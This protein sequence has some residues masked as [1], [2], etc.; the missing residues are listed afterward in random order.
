MILEDNANVNLKSAF[1]SKVQFF[2]TQVTIFTFDVI[3]P[4]SIE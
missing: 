3:N 2:G 1:T 4:F